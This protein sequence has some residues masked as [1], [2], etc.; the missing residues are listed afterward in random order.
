MPGQ[1]G[2][3]LKGFNMIESLLV[4]EWKAAA[5]AEGRLESRIDWLVRVV[6]GKYKVA[7]EE[8]SEGIRACR[9]PEKLDRWLDVALMVD[10]LE[11]F[12]R[13]TGL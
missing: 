6:K 3:P 7:A 12:R 13:Q 2:T 9:D 11:E 10:T 4:R 5:E 1:V 8:V